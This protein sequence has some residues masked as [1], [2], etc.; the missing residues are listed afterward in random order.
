MINKIIQFQ[1]VTETPANHS[2]L[3]VLCEDGILWE[4]YNG[5]WQK[6]DT[7]PNSDLPPMPPTEQPDTRPDTPGNPQAQNI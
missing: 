4:Y 6:L 5:N 2:F 7:P 3:I 1:Y